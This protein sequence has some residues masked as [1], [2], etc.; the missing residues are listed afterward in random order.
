MSNFLYV[1][2]RAGGRQHRVKSGD[3]IVV[4]RLAAQNGESV[5]LSDVVMAEDSAGGVVVGGQ[6]AGIQVSA[7]V[8]EAFRGKKVRVFKMRRRKKSRTTAG[9]RQNLTRL[10]IG[11]I[12][13]GAAAK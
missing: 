9:H 8:E 1:T 5:V 7:T 2:V 3:V 11:D 10:R 4:N 13:A 6:T 12:T